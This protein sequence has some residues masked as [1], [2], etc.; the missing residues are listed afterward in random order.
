MG[1]ILILLSSLS[2]LLFTGCGGDPAPKKN[3][4]EAIRAKLEAA[5]KKRFEQDGSSVRI[6]RSDKKRLSDPDAYVYQG[7]VLSRKEEKKWK[8]EG[9]SNKEF[10]Q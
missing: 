6:S 10:P 9:I 4:I 5:H 7:D 1:K 3:S 8:K 2:L